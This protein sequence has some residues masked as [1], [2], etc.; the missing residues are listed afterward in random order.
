[1]R[2]WGIAATAIYCLILVFLLVPTAGWLLTDGT[3]T[4]TGV[5]LD[6]LEGMADPDAWFGWVFLI[7]LTGAH[8]VLFGVAVD[9]TQR[10]PEARAHVLRTTA[11]VVLAVALLTCALL[12]SIA[13][14]IGGDDALEIEWLIWMLLFV[15]WLFWG[16]VLYL[17][18]ERVSA[19]LEMILGWLIKGSVLELLVAVPCHVIVRQRDEC[20]APGVTA[21]GIATGI[22]IMLMALG[23][24]VVFLYQRRV[25]E[26]R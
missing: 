20:S 13:M 4:V 14:A 2:R 15:P 25:S 10:R 12:L 19:R 16:S 1:M 5:W 6:S 23:P 18:R 22:A 3:E 7:A 11:A 8:Y 24:A 26:Y 9:T 17:Y 21:L